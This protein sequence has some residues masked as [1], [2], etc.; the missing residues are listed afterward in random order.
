MPPSTHD[1][2]LGTQVG[3]DFDGFSVRDVDPR[4]HLLQSDIAPITTTLMN[5][6]R[7]KRAKQVKVEWPQRETLPHTTRS[8]GGN[9]SS[10]IVLDIDNPEYAKVGDYILNQD[11]GELMG[12][13]IGKDDAN[14]QVTLPANGR[15]V[16]GT[17]AATIADNAPLIFMRGNIQEGG[18]ASDALNTLPT[19]EYNYIEPTSTTYKNT[20]LLELSQTYS[21]VH[22]WRDLRALKMK[23]HMEDLEKKVLYGIRG[24][25]T[26]GSQAKFFMGGLINQYLVSTIETVNVGVG[27]TKTF[28]KKQ[29]E[30][31]IRRLFNYN[32]SSRRKTVY[33]SSEI[34][35]TI[36]DFK[37]QALT[38]RNNDMMI[39]TAV[40]SYRSN[41]G[42]VDL[43][44][45]RFLNV[46]FG[47]DWYAV[48]LD[49]RNIEWLNFKPQQIRENIQEKRSHSREDEIYQVN[50]MKVFNEPTSGIFRVIAMA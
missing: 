1:G 28:T 27:G 21:N 31:F 47:T 16:I 29:W 14:N 26:T 39:N 18:F 15:G 46:D 35:E 32:Q 12:P 24:I 5:I 3:H 19:M 42:I 22:T 40:F 36:S 13:L 43:V 4:M 50:S 17:S 23:D 34:L 49:L 7:G 9:N 8:N 37:Y 45:Q 38:L 10:D 48:G 6:S 41:F 2:T 30:T 33:C 25:D 44:H 20:D 11:T